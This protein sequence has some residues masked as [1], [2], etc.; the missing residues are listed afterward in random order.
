M[1]LIQAA[2][3]GDMGRALELWNSGA[4]DADLN[5]I[6]ND[7][8]TALIMASANGHDHIVDLLLN[9]GADPNLKD[10]DGNTPLIIASQEG[11]T[12]IVK[13]LL[14]SGADPNLKDDAGNTPLIEALVEEYIDIVKLLLDS[15]ADP[16]I[17][18]INGQT[19][20]DIALDMEYVNYDIVRLIQDHIDQDEQS[21]LDEPSD[22]D[23][24]LLRDEAA[25]YIQ[26]IMRAR[27]ETDKK[28]K[29][30]KRRYG[31]WASPKTEREKHRRY[32]D[33]IRQTDYDDPMKGYERYAI[34]P[35]RL[36]P[37]KKGGK[38]NRKYYTLRMY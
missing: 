15:G 36:L 24:D 13:L 23:I 11:H 32:M 16:N 34:Y 9:A 2:S 3:N 7:G 17:G 22:P 33:L 5:I 20:Y 8:N 12:E 6:D 14:D 30:T 1:D 31:K 18:D 4:L 21:D 28:R 29:L 35:E 38:R 19:P 27:I 37:P 26:T 25:R 10:D